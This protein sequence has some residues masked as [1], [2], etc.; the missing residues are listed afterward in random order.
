MDMLK[1]NRF[2]VLGGALLVS[3]LLIGATALTVGAQANRNSS[4]DSSG[5]GGG[6]YGGMMGMGMMGMGSM[7][8]DVDRHFI[9]QMIPHHQGAIAMADLALQKAQRPE[10]KALAAD[11]KRTQTA[12]IEQ[13]RAWYKEWY[14]VDVPTANTSTSSS[15]GNMMGGGMSS[16]MGGGMNMNG[17]TQDLA[18]ATD[19]DKAFI[20]QMI[21]HHQMAVMMAGMVL[22]GGE[23]AELR[24]LVQSIST[25]QSA[26]IEKMRAW[27]K[28]WYGTSAP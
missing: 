6:G 10:I 17:N 2:L 14:G 12:E 27:Y 13:M 20:E 8:G 16:M 24:T 21:P 23:K 9:E 1:K 3:A 5:C 19:F 4:R 26:E 15:S 22:A 11:I 28:S 25:S 7:M 18:T